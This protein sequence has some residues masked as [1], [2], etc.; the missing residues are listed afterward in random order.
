MIQSLV[1][2]L[3]HNSTPPLHELFWEHSQA[4]PFIVHLGTATGS[5]RIR[6]ML[7]CLFA[8]AVLLWRYSFILAQNKFEGIKETYHLS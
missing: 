8:K 2:G 4:N 5:K 6:Y 7:M 3:D 1:L